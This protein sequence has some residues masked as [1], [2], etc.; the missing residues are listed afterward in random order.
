M[1]FTSGATLVVPDHPALAGELL[2]QTLAELEITHSLI[3]P[4]ALASLPHAS[5]RSFQ[6]SLSAGRPAAP[7]WWRAGARDGA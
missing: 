1:A 5:C 6:H 4:T 2:A 3:P 7:S